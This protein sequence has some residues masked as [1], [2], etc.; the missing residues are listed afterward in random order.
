MNEL[1]PL[2]TSFDI[3][4]SHLLVFLTEIDWILSCKV[5]AHTVVFVI[6]PRTSLK[7]RHVSELYTILRRRLIARFQHTILD[8][9][10][11]VEDG[12]QRLRAR[13]HC[14][15]GRI[16]TPLVSFASLPQ[17]QRS[18]HSGPRPK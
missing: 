8:D 3:S 17:R 7:K 10:D 15:G 18:F 6:M 2:E 5:C 11:S 1:R 14:L 13:W 4:D 16:Q 9:D 12:C